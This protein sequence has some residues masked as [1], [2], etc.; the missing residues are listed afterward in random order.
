MAIRQNLSAVHEVD[1]EGLTIIY[2]PGANASEVF[3]VNRM[4]ESSGG[5]VT[6]VLPS[7]FTITDVDM[8]CVLYMIEKRNKIILI[9]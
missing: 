8:S 7:S 4:S 9:L 5:R 6:Y 2:L 3:P 1:R